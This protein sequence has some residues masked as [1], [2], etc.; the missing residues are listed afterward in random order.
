MK[1]INV[2]IIGAGRAAQLHLNAYRKVYGL[3]ICIA[4][5]FD[6]D[7]KRAEAMK[8]E[9][10]IEKT[11]TSLN[12]ILMNQNIDIIDICTP[13]YSH[14]DLIIQALNH[15]KHVICEKPLCGFFGDGDTDGKAMYKAVKKD[16]R[17]LENCIQKS[18]RK[19]FYAEN[20]VYAPAIQKAAEII[21]NKKSKIL[22]A[23]GEESLAGSS[24]AVAG[25]WN[26]T[27]GGSLIR[28]GCHPLSAILYLK[29][30]N[31]KNITVTDVKADI[32]CVT[33]FLTKK[34]HRYIK[35]N[36]VDVE[37]T[38]VVTLSFSD[39]TKAVIIAC[40][41]RLGGSKNYVELYCN[42]TF[43]ECNLTLSDMMR[44]YFLDETG[45]DNVEISEMLQTKTGWNRP[46]IE[47][48]V[49]RG[50]TNEMQDFMECIAYNH[51]PQADFKLAKETIE[52]IYKA[53]SKKDL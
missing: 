30:I 29:K 8:K 10:R 48:E 49:I 47:D 16:I 2:A 43:L 53:Y 25:Y 28:V 5:L 52:I 39:N 24:S 45:L 51:K 26:K 11:A 36:P 31:D 15:N 20:F 18:N 50:Y 23:K 19:F 9:Y 6:S 35:A 34:Q 22:F 33:N 38:A 21:R 1:K 14:K 46:F 27:G 7:I 4:C 12:E 32:S 40:D 37:D 42:D 17:E 13:P 44:T 3:D 41:S